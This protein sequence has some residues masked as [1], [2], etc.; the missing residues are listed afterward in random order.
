MTCQANTVAC[1]L[2]AISGMLDLREAKCCGV[3][4]SRQEADVMGL[5]VN[6]LSLAMSNEDP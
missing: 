4:L 6:F 3:R 2:G 5:D 1:I